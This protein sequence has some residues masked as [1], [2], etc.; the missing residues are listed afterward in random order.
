MRRYEEE[1]RQGHVRSD[2]ALEYALTVLFA[3]NYDLE[4]ARAAIAAQPYK[5]G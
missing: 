1:A 5:V 3:H 4:A 2:S